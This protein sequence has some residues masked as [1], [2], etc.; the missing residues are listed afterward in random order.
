MQSPMFRP[1]EEGGIEELREICADGFSDLDATQ[2]S[3]KTQYGRL[4]VL[5]STR[6]GPID[7][8]VGYRR[9]RACDAG[10]L[11]GQDSAVLRRDTEYLVGVVADGVSQSFYGNLAADH[12]SRWLRE[13]LWRRRREPPDELALENSLSE[14]AKSLAVLANSYS[15]D[16]LPEWQRLALEKTREKGSQAV[17][18][19]F[20]WD[21]PA[22][23]IVLYQ[24]GDVG[25]IVLQAGGRSSRVEPQDSKGRWSTAGKSRMALFRTVWNEVNGIVIKSDGADS[26][27]GSTFAADATSGSAFY[28]MARQRAE[29]DDV[30]FISAWVAEGEETMR[31]R[32][33]RTPSFSSRSTPGSEV[34]ERAQSDDE[35]APAC[36]SDP[37]DSLPLKVGRLP[38]KAAWRIFARG[39]AC[40]FLAALAVSV[41]L[42]VRGYIV[43]RSSAGPHAQTGVPVTVKPGVQKGAAGKSSP[44][45][46]TERPSTGLSP[47]DKPTEASPPK[48]QAPKPDVPR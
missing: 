27:W 11:P 2:K 19:A 36:T 32:V 44:R 21:G 16:H 28:E 37:P 4:R 25:A 39:V 40:G 33:I 15:L 45:G 41:W 30:S 22:N 31:P 46:A 26:D 47:N 18:A 12:I 5:E 29:I 7:V 10:N 42:F 38:S 34:V 9:L 48:E 3:E 14:Q 13:E 24:V 17:F 6:A 8:R 35:T 1:D 23:Q 43:W 20:I